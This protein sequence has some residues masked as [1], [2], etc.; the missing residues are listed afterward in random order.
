MSMIW[1]KSRISSK[2]PCIWFSSYQ[3]FASQKFEEDFWLNP[4]LQI[5][6]H[7]SP[8]NPCASDSFLTCSYQQYTAQSCRALS[9]SMLS[10]PICV[11]WPEVSGQAFC[12][13]LIPAS[14]GVPAHLADF[15]CKRNKVKVVRIQTL[16]TESSPVKDCV[17]RCWNTQHVSDK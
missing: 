10:E 13:W 16:L 15:S 11:W 14:W 3:K 8:T 2:C 1:N 6:K 9:Q 17:E 12:L 4:S 5:P 7:I